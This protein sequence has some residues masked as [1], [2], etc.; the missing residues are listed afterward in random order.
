MEYRTTLEESKGC[1]IEE[2]EKT[3]QKSKNQFMTN[4]K[5]HWSGR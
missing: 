2:A 4:F 3:N 5:R 1:A